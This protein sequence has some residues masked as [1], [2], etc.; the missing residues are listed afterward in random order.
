MINNLF[1]DLWHR[2]NFSDG[3]IDAQVITNDSCTSDGV[4]FDWIH[5]NLYWTDSVDKS[6]N[7]ALWDGSYKKTLINENLD[8]PRAIVVDPM[9]G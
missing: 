7:V 2:L 4:A 3:S 1:F 9:E 5:G 6:I 8:E